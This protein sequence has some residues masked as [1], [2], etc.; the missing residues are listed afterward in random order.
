MGAC[1]HIL[2]VGYLSQILCPL[3]SSIQPK[4]GS[5]E[6]MFKKNLNKSSKYAMY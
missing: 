3:V 5:N 4:K 1:F 2:D 6:H